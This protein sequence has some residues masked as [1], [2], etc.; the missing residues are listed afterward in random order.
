MTAYMEHKDLSN[1]SI[2]D[3]RRAEITSGVHCTLDAVQ[4]ALAKAGRPSDATTL[5]AATKT[6]DV[7]E[8]LAAVDA[9]IRCIGENR[10][11]EVLAKAEGL[12]TGLA[13]RGLD[14]MPFHMIGQLQANKISKILPYISTIESVDSLKLAERISRRLETQ[15]NHEIGI[16]LE[17]NESGEDTKSGC[18]PDEAYDIAQQIAELEGLRLEGLMTIGTHVSDEKVVR[19]GFAHLRDLRDR[20]QDAGLSACRE[21]S[22]GMSGD[23]EWAIAEGSTLVRV[24]TGIFGERA[25]I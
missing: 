16:F 4:N 3:E 10:P 24:G 8:I 18:S 22:M 14:E 21:L 19:T 13:D 17:V 11:Q 6:R 2:T 9:G 23:M 20:L 12:A 25:F 1:T 7:A 5:L 15:E